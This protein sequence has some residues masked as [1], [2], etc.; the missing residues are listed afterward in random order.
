MINKA[1]GTGEAK[2]GKST[3]SNTDAGRKG[4]IL[5]N[6]CFSSQ[7]TSAFR[8]IQPSEHQH[9][10]VRVKLQQPGI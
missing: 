8:I 6:K 9:G 3:I 4:K 1:A 10:D 5:R 7:T 2:A